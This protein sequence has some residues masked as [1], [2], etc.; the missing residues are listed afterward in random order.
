MARINLRD[1]SDVVHHI[2]SQSALLNH[3]SIEGEAR[4]ALDLYAKE[5]STPKEQSADTPRGT[6]QK[7]VA[8]RLAALFQKLRDDDFFP[9]KTRHDAP[10]IAKAIGEESPAPLL[11]CL[12]G[13]GTLTFDMADRIVAWSSC[14]A[15][16]L[17]SG[18]GAMFPVEDIGSSYQSFF[19]SENENKK[20]F[21]FYLIRISSGRNTGMILCIKHDKAAETYHAGYIA[22]HFLLSTGMGSGG[23]GN[24]KR[25]IIFLKT[26]CHE[27]YLQASEFDETELSTELGLH[28]PFWYMQ[29]KSDSQWLMQLFQGEDPKDWLEGNKTAWESVKSLPFGGIKSSSN[30][31]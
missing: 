29:R 7:G 2:I 23:H 31:V 21:I 11:D 12:N 9:Y 27:H 15:S 28:H 19:V 22:T 5:I 20:D 4:Y 1:L 26:Y 14:S 10:H 3:R 17:L 13:E 8:Q 30:E 25:F 6:W 16:W 24:L 18:A